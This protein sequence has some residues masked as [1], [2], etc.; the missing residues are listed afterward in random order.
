M[1]LKESGAIPFWFWNGDQQETEI[2]RQ[3]EMAKKGGLRGL[4]FHAR[5]GNLTEYLSPRWMELVR[6]ACV[7]AKRLGLEL[8]LYDEEGFPSGTV[9]ERLPQL[10][11]KYQ[12]KR[13]QWQYMSGA[14]AKKVNIL[15]AFC[16]GK[17]IAAGEIE[18][19]MEN[20]LVFERIVLPRFTDCFSHDAARKF[21]EMTHEKYEQAIG[22]FLGN[23]VTALYTDDIQYMFGWE[24]HL[25]WSDNLE[26]I[27]REKYGVSLL[28]NLAALVVDGWNDTIRRSYREMIS[29]VLNEIFVRPMREWAQKHGMAFTGHLCGDEGPFQL[30]IRCFGDASAFYLEEDIPG[31]DDYLTAS[32]NLAYMREPRNDF[33]RKVN[34]VNGF[35]ITT[36]VKQASSVAGQLKNGL[37]SSETLT[38]RGWG[39]PVREQ[40]AQLF[41]EYVLGINII[42]PHDCSYTTDRYTKRDHPASFFFQ[43]PYFEFNS[44]LHRASNRTM[45]LCLRGRVD[46]DVLVIHPVDSMNNDSDAAFFTEFM[47]DL[48][49]D[50]LRKHIS[51]EYGYERVIAQSGSVEGALF[52][53][54]DCAYSV[55][56]LPPLKYISENLQKMLAVF[57]SNG[58]KVLRLQTPCMPEN[59][60]APDLPA[61]PAEVAVGRRIVDGKREYYL[62]NFAETAQKITF[63]SQNFELY[64]PLAN[65]LVQTDGAFIL[66][67]LKSVHLLP[68]GTLEDVP[69]Q[70]LK[71]SMLSPCKR[72]KFRDLQWKITPCDPNVMVIDMA[73]DTAGG[74]MV[75][76]DRTME[77]TMGKT[78]AVDFE[79]PADGAFFFEPGNIADICMDGVHAPEASLTHPATQALRGF[80]VPA[81][82]HSVTFRSTDHRLEYSYLTG[83]FS[84]DLP[85]N[86]VPEKTLPFGDLI[87][88]GLPFYWGAVA[89]ET[90]FELDEIPASLF[91]AFDHAEGVVAAEINGVLLDAL[92][93]SPWEFDLTPH[94]K[95]GTNTLKLILRNTAQNF[96]GPHRTQEQVN[97]LTAWMPENGA[98][99][100]R[101]ASFG[102]FDQPKLVR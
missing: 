13:L 21:L 10:G 28:D 56:I 29:T 32:Q 44:S 92:Y 102:I 6:H 17:L 65:T 101:V 40:M 49:L 47:Q 81:G 75:Q 100:I 95:R 62:V 51:F 59:I 61:I 25:P 91:A 73:L 52:R 57:E 50:L 83:N 22:E 33:G 66:P 72:E 3:M 19:H 82:K 85:G 77:S 93:T 84:V 27:F 41:F 23:T 99:D 8:Y 67:P 86:I 94:L 96:F 42:V 64:D 2:T 78:F 7:E 18:E 87:F 74:G 89:Y 26:E 90:Q 24:Q 15:R 1:K 20:V 34:L 76:F 69:V 88:A 38:S 63:D 68:A 46:A 45:G 31:V 9:G 79:L 11:E 4:A 55:V 80:S 54:G 12:Q 16:N 39:I 30:M 98:E 5:E 53:I 14:D 43:Q 71:S 48:N 60:I 70:T 35:P 58:G 97:H 36:L 37:C